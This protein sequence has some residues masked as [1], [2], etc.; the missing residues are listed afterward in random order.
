ME[1]YMEKISQLLMTVYKKLYKYSQAKKSSSISMGTCNLNK[2]N[3]GNN[4][5]HLSDIN[6]E[7][8]HDAK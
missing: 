3:I 7:E 2:K 1:I 8:E 6:K 4:L 5:F